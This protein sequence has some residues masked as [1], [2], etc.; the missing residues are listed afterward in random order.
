MKN[1]LLFYL[2]TLVVL[3]ILPIY[4]QDVFSQTLKIQDYTIHRNT[5]LTIEAKSH[6][7]LNILVRIADVTDKNLVVS[8]R[9]RNYLHSQR[10]SISLNNRNLETVVEFIVGTQGLYYFIRPNEIEV[11]ESATK[12]H[13]YDL[14][15]KGYENYLLLYPQSERIPQ[16]YFSL[17]MF[18]H[19]QGNRKLEFSK[20]HNLYNQFPDHPLVA[21]ALLFMTKNLMAGGE[22][23]KARKTL[24]KYL[25]KFNNHKFTDQAYLLLAECYKKEK[26]YSNSKEIYNYLLRHS[27]ALDE[28]KLYLEIGRLLLEQKQFTK[29]AEMFQIVIDKSPVQSDRRAQAAYEYIL[30]SYSMQD[31]KKAEIQIA[32]FYEQYPQSSVIANVRVLHGEIAFNQKDY[33]KSYSLVKPLLK[34]K[35]KLQAK[36]ITLGVKSLQKLDLY[37]EAIRLLRSKIKSLPKKHKDR[38]MLLYEL[39]NIY[40]ETRHWSKA[41]A[42]FTGIASKNSDEQMYLRILECDL[43]AKNYH[44]CVS[45]FQEYRPLINSPKILSEAFSIL[46]RS[47]LKLG[48]VKDAELAFAGK[49]K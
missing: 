39:A 18:W 37:P 14:V 12:E 20:F 7:L 25:N 31:E 24:S 5:F 33:F 48:R 10:L 8:K 16:I 46:G 30:C 34:D 17:G 49:W 1:Y 3:C 44:S 47:F 11:T 13:M 15:T 28:T 6:N 45:G 27:T 26:D 43:S 21:G 38:N 36:A 29:A 19:L 41:K 2:H 4:A 9:L 40:Y 22:Y 42:I 35:H 32:S 23:E